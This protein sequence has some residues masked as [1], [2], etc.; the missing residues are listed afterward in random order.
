MERILSP[1]EH[2]LLVHASKLI[3]DTQ[4]ALA[5]QDPNSAIL[6]AFLDKFTSSHVKKLNATYQQVKEAHEVPARAKH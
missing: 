6:L 2:N 5:R 3:L 4:Y 1:E